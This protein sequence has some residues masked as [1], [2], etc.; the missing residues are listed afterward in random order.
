MR[1]KRFPTITVNDRDSWRV[2][3]AAN[4]ESADGLWLVHFKKGANAGVGREESVEEALCFGWI[5]SLVKRIDDVRR[6]RM[7]R[8]GP[9]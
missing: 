1:R 6:A 4:H 5:D 7:L 8:S 9:T 3:L 2:W